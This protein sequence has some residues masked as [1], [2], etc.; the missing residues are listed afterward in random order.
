M[1]LI[2][3]TMILS[4]DSKFFELYDSIK[5]YETSVL[6]TKNT[7]EDYLIKYTFICWFHNLFDIRNK[8]IKIKENNDPT[9]ISD[10]IKDIIFDINHRLVNIHLNCIKASFG[11][12]NPD[13]SIKIDEFTSILN[14]LN[15]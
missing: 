3:D 7:L 8:M 14:S 15:N 11:I 6:Y 4:T 9:F 5:Q 13:V 2:T 12:D 10:T 1:S